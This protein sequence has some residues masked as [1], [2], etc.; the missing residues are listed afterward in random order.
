MLELDGVLLDL[1]DVGI[2]QLPEAGDASDRL[3]RNM[4]EAEITRE[5]PERAQARRNARFW[6][7]DRIMRPRRF[8][9]AGG[10]AVVA[11]AIGGALGLDTASAPPSALAKEMNHLGQLAASQAPTGI[12]GPGQYLYTVSYQQD[13]AAAPSAVA[14]CVVSYVEEDQMWVAADGSGVIRKSIRDLRFAS[15]AA[16]AACTSHG[17]TLSSF[18]GPGGGL[19]YSTTRVP[20]GGLSLQTEDWK[21][22]STDPATLLQ[23]VH[24][25]DGG[26]NTPEEWFTNVAD[27]MHDGT[28]APPAIRAA[29]YQATALIPGVRSL[30][31]QTTSDGQTGLAVAFY[32]NGKPTHELIFDQQTGR[33]LEEAYYNDGGSPDVVDYPADQ[34]TIVD[35]IPPT[36]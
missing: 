33:L 26:A 34:T 28:D 35:S 23:Q 1:R 11:L 19:D 29:L 7:G 15:A 36:S 10:M 31:T 18:I 21:S 24:Q 20:A 4:L 13:P 27:F 12:P 3:A 6:R 5:H 14:S 25:K 2:R 17:L 16:Q 9:L 32:A 8:A 30:G 22:L